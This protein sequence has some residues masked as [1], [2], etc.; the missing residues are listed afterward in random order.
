MVLASR[1]PFNKYL[2][3]F[4]IEEPTIKVTQPSRA[5]VDRYPVSVVGK[6]LLFSSKVDSLLGGSLQVYCVMRNNQQAGWLFNH[7][8]LADSINSYPPVWLCTNP[9]RQHKNY[10]L[11]HGNCSFCPYPLET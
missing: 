6:R 11:D 7:E 5:I 2:E 3:K 8:Y 4:I 1:S 9:E 10:S